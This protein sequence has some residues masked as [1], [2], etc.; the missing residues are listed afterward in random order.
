M[1]E[2]EEWSQLMDMDPNAQAEYLFREGITSVE[3][4]E[5]Q[6]E[7][8]KRLLFFKGK[9]IQVLIDNSQKLVEYGKIVYQ[10]LVDL[11]HQVN[12]GYQGT[13]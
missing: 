5:L 9:G 6:W 3:Y 10:K 1:T 2:S 11:G 8:E 13:R 7:R 4:K 12:G